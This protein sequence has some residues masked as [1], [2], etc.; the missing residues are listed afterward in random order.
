MAAT[1]PAL[2]THLRR[3]AIV[4]LPNSGKTVLLTSL[5]IHL[6]NRSAAPNAGGKTARQKL[7]TWQLARHLSGV[8][9]SAASA[10]APSHLVW[11]YREKPS[12]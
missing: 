3:V 5:L 1:L 9:L 12:R 8:I 4:G 11:P 6:E 2:I 7:F 10:M